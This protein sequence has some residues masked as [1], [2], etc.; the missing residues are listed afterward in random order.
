MVV[1]RKVFNTARFWFATMTDLKT[2]I[3]CAGANHDIYCY[4]DGSYKFGHRD[5]C[6]DFALACLDEQTR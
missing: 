2:S 6:R 5:Y 1:K 3:R 4:G